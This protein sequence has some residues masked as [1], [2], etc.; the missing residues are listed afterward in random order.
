M[1]MLQL[2]LEAVEAVVALLTQ[3]LEELAA[4]AVALVLLVVTPQQQVD[5]VVLE[6]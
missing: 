6:V 1:H 2:F 5:L 3:G 4:E